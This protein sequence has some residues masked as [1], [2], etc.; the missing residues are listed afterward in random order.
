MEKK[1]VR[2]ED[3]RLG[4]YVVELD[5]PWLGTVFDPAGFPLV[6]ADQIDSLRASC[7]TVYVDPQRESS[8][9]ACTSEAHVGPVAYPE[10]APVEQELVV[11]RAIYREC[12][13]AIRHSLENL[14]RAERIDSQKLTSAVASMTRS[15]QRNPDA[16]MLLNTL[17]QKDSYELGRALDTSVLMVTFGRF[18]QFPTDRLEILGLAGLLLDVGKAKLPDAVLRARQTLAPRE[19]ELVKAHVAYSV[20]LIRAARGLPPGVDEIV[21]LHHERQD[22]S[23]YPGGLRGGDISIDGAI[24]ALV[25]SY[26]A[27]TSSRPYAEQASSSDALSLLHKLRGKLFHE[28]LVE[29][30]VQCVGIYPVGSAVELNTGEVSI[31]IAQNLVRRLQPRVMVILDSRWQPIPQRILDLVSGPPARGD[32]PYRIR[33]TLPKHTLP[34]DPDEFFL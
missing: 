6:S 4:M 14:T 22:G 5:R 33:R 12:Q 7:R 26:S 28:A 29:Q 15:I 27:L 13:D 16:M 34:I 24:A 18:L 3:L 32:E 25:D 31:V 1:Q 21:A 23:G 9:A 11:A 2:V 10:L 17:W 20:D 8:V 30:F 19:Y